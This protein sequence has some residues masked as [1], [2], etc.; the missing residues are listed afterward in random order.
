MLESQPGKD[1]LGK[2]AQTKPPTPPPAL[3]FQLEPARLKRNREPKGKEVVDTGKTLPSQ[4]DKAQ[5]TAKQVKIGKR[6]AERRSEPQDEPLAWLLAPMLDGVPLLATTSI[7]NFQG[8]TAGYMADAVKQALL[9]PEDMA[10][11]QSMRRYKI[12]LSLKRYHAM[13]CLL[14]DP[15]FFSFSL[16]P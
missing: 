2:A 8:A 9:L 1:A 4:E 13:V 7:R 16:I 3:P 5:R 11:L 15:L 14:L 6:G 12:F 10:E